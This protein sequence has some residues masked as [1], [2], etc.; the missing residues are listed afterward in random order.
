MKSYLNQ[1]ENTKRGVSVHPKS[2]VPPAFIN[3]QGQDPKCNAHGFFENP[4]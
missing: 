4:V 1:N 3:M 2:F